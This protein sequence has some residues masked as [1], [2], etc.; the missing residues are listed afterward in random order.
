MT[1]TQAAAHSVTASNATAAR[2]SG[3]PTPAIPARAARCS[4]TTTTCSSERQEE[5]T[6]YQLTDRLH[7]GRTVR[8]KQ[9]TSRRSVGMRRIPAIFHSPPL[10]KTRL[11]TLR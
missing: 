9:I 8:A 2:L 1:V 6:V 11:A 7:D 3:D 4:A 10:G 5:M